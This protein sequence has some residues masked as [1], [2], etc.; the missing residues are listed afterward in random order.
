MDADGAIGRLLEGGTSEQLRAAIRNVAEATTLDGDLKYSTRVSWG[1]KKMIACRAYAKDVLQLCHLINAVDAGG[2]GVERYES[3]FFCSDQATARTF[4][5]RFDHAFAAQGRRGES[6]SRTENGISIRYAD[7]I[8]N[9]SY[10]RMPLLA[11]LLEFLIETAGYAEI[12]AAVEEILSLPSQ[13]AVVEKAANRISRSLYNYLSDHLPTVQNK[14]KFEQLVAFLQNSSGEGPKEIDD[15]TVLNFWLEHSADPEG[16]D[17]RTYRSVFDGFVSLMRALDA[18]QTQQSTQRAAPIGSDFDAGEIEL[19]SL[20]ATVDPIS[21]WQSPLAVLMDDPVN[22]I[23][24]LNEVERKD[25][26]LLMGRGPLAIDLPLSVLRYEVF[27]LSQ[28]R[29][30]QGLRRHITAN[31]MQVLV[32]CRDAGTYPQRMERYRQLVDH[33]Q[34]VLKASLYVLM[35]Q[36]S[37]EDTENVVGLQ[38]D[39]PLGMFNSMSDTDTD[40]D[41]DRLDFGVSEAEDAFKRFN[42]A[43]FKEETIHEPDIVEGF[44][45]GSGAMVA[46][47]GQIERYLAVITGIDAGQP[48]LAD[49]GEQDRRMF[50]AQFGCIYG[51]A[52]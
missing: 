40:I 13:R 22:R 37:H 31:E 11:A 51:E 9:V 29:I 46:V 49:W 33:V 17:F 12:D 21:E 2:R 6:L 45:I 10:G 34:R 24:F 4:A 32:S 8:F 47:K 19:D 41:D 39:D 50:S 36:S 16:G 14:I 1:L 25:L 38:Q 7:G 3:F 18:A 23:K 15:E 5:H 28:S 43:G 44:R 52:P 30:R 20:S 42:R 48:D 27:G 35:R 26:D